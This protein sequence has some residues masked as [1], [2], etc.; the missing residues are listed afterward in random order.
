M[1]EEYT[2]SKVNSG[3]RVGVGVGL[4]VGVGVGVTSGLIVVVG[5]GVVSGSVSPPPSLSSHITL[6]ILPYIK[7]CVK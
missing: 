3:S 2:A 6:H 5:V 1:F 7:K 4:A